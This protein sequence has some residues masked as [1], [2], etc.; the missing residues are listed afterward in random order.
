MRIATELTEGFRI[1]WN[2][3]GA[4][5]VRSVL[6]TLGIVVGIVTVTVMGAAITGLN[7]YF[8]ESFSLMGADVIYVE[9]FA[10]FNNE[11]EWQSSRNRRKITL[12]QARLLERHVSDSAK[13]VAP[14]CFSRISLRYNRK[15]AGNV[16][17]LGTTEKFEETAGITV[18]QGRYMTG[19]EV[20]GSR[21]VCVIGH[22][23]ASRLFEHESPIG[24]KITLGE[25][26]FEVIGVN[27]KRGKFMGMFSMDEEI[28]L[29]I[30][31]FISTISSRADVRIDVKVTDLSK[32][33]DAKEEL[34]GAMRKVRSLKPDARDDFAINQQDMFVRNFNKLGG[35]IA[36]IGLFITGL[37]L[38]VGG[39]G[40]MNIMFVSV[41]E[42]TKE[43][44]IRKAIGARRR[45][46]LVQF[47]IEAIVICLI[48]GAVGLGIAWPIT[49]ALGKVLPATMS[50]PL[51]AV[52]LGVSMFTGVISGFM[53]AYRASKMN[54]VDAL[55]A[56]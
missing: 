49:M 18:A 29:P 17:V 36:A 3:I 39:I 8:K 15:S 2:A 10:W 46:I 13:A 50:L 4:N 12:H 51:V 6:T 11:E 26:S 21:P 27:E 16:F 25:A 40:I 5:K 37:S 47:L 52:A 33:E 14:V 34:R 43:I 7:R 44:G 41:T 32:L 55:R 48:G 20:N 56:E 38:F 9:R 1:S 23:I 45:T 28:H 31:Q 53:P 35:T 54:P 24:K 22:D 42:R 30:T 19:P